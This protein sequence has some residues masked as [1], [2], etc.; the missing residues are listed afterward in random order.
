M[1]IVM[2]Q[3]KENMDYGKRKFIPILT[4]PQ[5]GVMAFL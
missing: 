2:T 1:I 3:W 5:L 4:K